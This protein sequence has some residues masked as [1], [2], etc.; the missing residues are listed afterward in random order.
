MDPKELLSEASLQ[1]DGAPALIQCDANGIILSKSSALTKQLPHSFAVGSSLFQALFTVDETANIKESLNRH[2]MYVS[3]PL[4]FRHRSY[5][6]A[7][8]LIK[9][10][11]TP[12]IIC[13]LDEHTAG[14]NDGD[15]LHY[16]ALMEEYDASLLR[17]ITRLSRSI[18]SLSQCEHIARMSEA[19]TR[20][21]LLLDVYIAMSR[22]GSRQETVR[23]KQLCSEIAAGLNAALQ[24]QQAKVSI[25]ASTGSKAL[26]LDTDCF[27]QMFFCLITLYH[28][29]A[30]LCSLQLTLT[31]KNGHVMLQASGICPPSAEVHRQKLVGLLQRVIERFAAYYDGSAM[32]LQDGEVLTAA[33]RFTLTPSTQSGA[34][35]IFHHQN[36]RLAVIDRTLPLILLAD[37]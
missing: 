37:R 25:F 7:L 22:V 36:D 5:I 16:R 20:N 24:K 30:A 21:R 14:E 10:D 32:F 17:E 18:T 26:F 29:N 33:I 9:P 19:L 13:K 2:A 28:Q 1:R 35:E 6:A 12:Y 23:L 34:E 15:L 4:S 11:R 31:E 3:A 27:I 8:F